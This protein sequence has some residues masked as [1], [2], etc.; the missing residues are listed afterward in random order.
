LPPTS[1]PSTGPAA[2][3]RAGAT[4]NRAQAGDRR[5]RGGR[6]ASGEQRRR[7]VGRELAELRDDRRVQRRHARGERPRVQ[8][9]HV[10][11]ADDELGRARQ[12]GAVEARQ[13]AHEPVAAARAEDRLDR[14]IGQ[15]RRQLGR[16][17]VV[18]AR[19]KS[20]A[21]EDALLVDKLVARS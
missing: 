2:R 3:A 19:E 12:R 11:E 14:R 9:R 1:G 6:F 8:R 16:A 17:R 5:R 18:V 7:V 20:G 15:R 21:R 4:I 10:G 13:D